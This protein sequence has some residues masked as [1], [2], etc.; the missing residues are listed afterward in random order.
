MPHE[1]IA[2]EAG[3]RIA[4]LRAGRYVLETDSAGTFDLVEA[5]ERGAVDGRLVDA[6]PAERLRRYYEATETTETLLENAIHAFAFQGCTVEVVTLTFLAGDCSETRH[7][8]I[9]PDEALAQRFFLRVCQLV[10]EVD[11]EILVFQNGSWERDPKLFEAV[12][13]ARLDDLVLRGALLE[14]IVADVKGFFA[15]EALYARYRIPHKRGILLYGPPG[16]GKTHFLKG[17]LA[18]IEVPCLYV[19]SLVNHHRNDHDA[20]RRIFV[21]ARAVAPCLLVLEDLETIVNDD[22]RSFFLNELDGF[23][24]NTGVAVLATT[25]YPERIDP[26]IIDRPSRFDRK[27]LFDL[28]ST[29]ERLAYLERWAGGLEAEMRPTAERLE[30]TAQKTRNFS[31]AYLKELTISATMA[32]VRTPRAGAMDA[33]LEDVVGTLKDQ[34]QK[35]RSP[36]NGS[37]TRRVGLIPEA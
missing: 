37:G 25:N 5:L 32:W 33:V 4:A 9:A 15:S 17:L 11:R 7:W 23:S 20:L 22:N 21:R 14:E 29:E 19:K 35:G 13:R 30:R 16:N 26:A 34:A 10:T 3:L 28:P 8:V 36:S 12:G 2:Y 24:E 18:T 27:Y 6:V 31:F 1:R